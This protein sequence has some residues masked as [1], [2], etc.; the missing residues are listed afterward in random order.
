MG[1]REFV[2]WLANPLIQMGLNSAFVPTG[3]C[4]KRLKEL[5]KNAATQK[6]RQT[7][8]IAKQKFPQPPIWM[9][10]G[11]SDG[12]RLNSVGMPN[13]GIQMGLCIQ[14]GVHS[15]GEGG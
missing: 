10:P 8:M 4:P 1:E 12:R 9:S 14:M 11:H 6:C 13:M 3:Y 7:K 2:S 5:T 15:E